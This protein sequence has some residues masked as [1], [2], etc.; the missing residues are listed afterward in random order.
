[1]YRKLLIII[2]IAISLLVGCSSSELIVPLEELGMAS[3]LAF[4]YI[5]EDTTKLS[6][7]VP[8]FMPGIGQKTDIYDVNT[9]LVSE[10]LLHIERQ[11]D[12]KVILNQLQV[13]LINEEFAQNGDVQSVIEY[14]YRKSEVGGKV[15]VAIVKGYGEEMLKSDY[16]DKPSINIYLNDLLQPNINTAF[17]PNTNLHDFI[18]TLTNPVYDSIIPVLEK[19][20]SKVEI[21]GVAL[22]KNKTMLEIIKPNDAL[23]IQALQGK[24]ELSPLILELKHKENKEKILLDLIQSKV[25]IKSNKDL[26]SPKLDIYLKI[27]GTLSEY[28]GK[29]RN[30]L[31]T[32]EKLSQLEHDINKQLEQEIQQLIEKTQRLEID[33]IGLSENFR[34][35]YKGKWNDQLTNSVVSKLQVDIRVETSIIST[36]I[37]E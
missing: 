22:F 23:I 17:N 3:I 6:V 32:H 35:Y 36:G 10:G 34:M 29:R 11:S 28:K 37:L 5:D 13:V 24:K 4:D 9:D 31:N 26:K 7:A 18:Y 30:N 20:D 2:S 16:P 33:P 12:K 8:Q 27:K 1:M 14:L 15:L 19:K 25:K 21:E